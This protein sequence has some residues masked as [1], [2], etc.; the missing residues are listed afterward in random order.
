MKQVGPRK[1]DSYGDMAHQNG[2]GVYEARASQNGVL[3]TV[4]GFTYGDMNK[5]GENTTLI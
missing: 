2:L 4:P 3:L 1:L 5:Y